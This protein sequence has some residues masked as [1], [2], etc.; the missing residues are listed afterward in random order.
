VAAGVFHQRSPRLV[1]PNAASR[2]V[3]CPPC[4]ALSEH[5]GKRPMNRS[6]GMAQLMA[7]VRTPSPGDCPR[8]CRNA[9]LFA[10]TAATP[11][12]HLPRHCAK[13]AATAQGDCPPPGRNVALFAETP[14]GAKGVIRRPRLSRTEHSTQLRRWGTAPW[15]GGLS[16]GS[17]KVLVR[18][19]AEVLPTENPAAHRRPH[20]IHSHAARLRARRFAR[21]AVRC[22]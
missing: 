4:I 9:A 21:A 22:H 14:S 6:R 3:V 16:P 5:A 10:G 2:S 20:V 15:N 1:A 17:Q 12:E 11:P 8:S 19:S 18:R 13:Y 7:L